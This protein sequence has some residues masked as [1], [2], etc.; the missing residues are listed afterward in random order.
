MANFYK[1]E[2]LK[3]KLFVK[4]LSLYLF[5]FGINENDYFETLPKNHNY[6]EA[7]YYI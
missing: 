3:Q 4:Q 6:D 2:L 1:N 7:I 5:F